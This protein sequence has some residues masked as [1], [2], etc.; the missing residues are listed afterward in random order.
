MELHRSSPVAE[1]KRG[2]YHICTASV[3]ILIYCP[4]DEYNAKPAHYWD[5][6]YSQHEDGFFKD[7]GWLRLEFPELVACSEA[8]VSGL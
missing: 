1:E 4:V 8:D 6:F 3:L 2:E 5:K 7:R